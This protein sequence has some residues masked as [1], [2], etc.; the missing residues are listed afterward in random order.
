[1][2]APAAGIDFDNL[3]GEGTFDSGEAYGRSKLANALFSLALAQR[4]EGTGVTSNV[5]HPGL[6]S[7]NIARTA[8]FIIREAFDLLGP[9]FAKSPAQGAATQV[10]VATSPLLDGVNGAYFEDC[11]PVTISGRHHM[12]DQA[13]AEHLWSVAQEM[14]TGYLV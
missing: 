9:L 5:I 1:M 14:T 7:T 12:F 8:P 6:V 13:M 2:Q 10:Y 3:R 4:L 11:N